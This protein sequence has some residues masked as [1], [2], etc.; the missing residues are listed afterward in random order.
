[1]RENHQG[2]YWM[3]AVQSDELPFDLFI[4]RN[5]YYNFALIPKGISA[6]KN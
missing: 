6:N 1:M 3:L 2:G 4:R 5:H